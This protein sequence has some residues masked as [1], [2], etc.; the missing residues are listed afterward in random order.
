MTSIIFKKEDFGNFELACDIAKGIGFIVE[1]KTIEVTDDSKIGPLIKHIRED[2]NW[3]AIAN[4]VTVDRLKIL[5]NSMYGYISYANIQ[6]LLIKL[7]RVNK[8]GDFIECIIG[9]LKPNEVN[10]LTTMPLFYTV[11]YLNFSA[12]LVLLKYNIPLYEKVS[13]TNRHN[14]SEKFT[15]LDIVQYASIK[16]T[17]HGPLGVELYKI[18]LNRYQAY[19]TIICDK[20]KKTRAVEVEGV[21]V[22]SD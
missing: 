10:Q 13:E 1:K 9:K 15:N 18:I 6:S 14:T 7:I 4:L 16:S 21:M 5:F 22:Y 3:E 17:Y 20:T 19:Y 8:H 2:F 12:A 11:D